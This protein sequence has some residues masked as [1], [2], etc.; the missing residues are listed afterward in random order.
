MCIFY[1]NLIILEIEGNLL[2]SFLYIRKELYS[3]HNM[4]V[5]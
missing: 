2:I 4:K 3:N 5:Y 1:R